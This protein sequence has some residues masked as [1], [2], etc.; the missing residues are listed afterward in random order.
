MQRPLGERGRKNP[1]NKTKYLE[2]AQFRLHQFN[3]NGLRNSHGRQS[4]LVACFRDPDG[5]I[6]IEN[7]QLKQIINNKKQQQKK[8]RNP[9]LTV[10]EIAKD[11][12]NKY[13]NRP[14]KWNRLRDDRRQKS[15]ET[16]PKRHTLWKRFDPQQRIRCPRLA[17]LDVSN[18]LAERQTDRQGRKKARVKAREKRNTCV[19][20]FHDHALWHLLITVIILDVATHLAEED[21]LLHELGIDGA[22]HLV[23]VDVAH[24]AV[25]RLHLRRRH[26][27]VWIR[28]EIP[29]DRVF[30][31]SDRVAVITVPAGSWLLVLVLL[32]LLGLLMVLLRR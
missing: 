9:H 13:N 27:R 29:S 23:A 28:Q 1:T 17:F 32:M 4:P 10:Q 15:S 3:P 19:I 2:R 24:A 20:C 25:D 31:K 6:V 14:I 12:L 5:P 30:Y 8:K 7:D 11:S 18:C 26:Y 22:A 16:L 21:A